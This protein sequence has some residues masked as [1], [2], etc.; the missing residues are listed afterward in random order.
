MKH[1]ARVSHELEARGQIINKQRVEEG[2]QR[3][4]VNIWLLI[5][6]I[7]LLLLDGYEVKKPV[8]SD[9]ESKCLMEDMSEHSSIISSKTILNFETVFNEH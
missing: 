7:R 1:S 6:I 8:N 4:E 3:R 5:L 9:L 2:V